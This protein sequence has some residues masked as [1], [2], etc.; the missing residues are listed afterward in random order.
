MSGCEGFDIRAYSRLIKTH[1]SV[2]Q[3]NV[4]EAADA[5]C[6]IEWGDEAVGKFPKVQA[7]IRG[8]ND[9]IRDFAVKD[10]GIF[11]PRV[12]FSGDANILYHSRLFL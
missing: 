12:S 5:R 6:P 11:Y 1:I 2:C 10:N 7:L 9:R 4:M 3:A 8:I